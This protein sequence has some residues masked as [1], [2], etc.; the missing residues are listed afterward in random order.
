VLAALGRTQ[1]SSWDCPDIVFPTDQT[2]ERGSNK[3]DNIDTDLEKNLRENIRLGEKITDDGTALCD[4]MQI[5]E[6]LRNSHESETV[7]AS[8]SASVGKAQ[9]DRQM[10]RKLTD[11][12]DDRDSITTNDGSAGHSSPKVMVSTKD[13]LKVMSGGSRAGSVP[14]GRESSVK[15]ED[16]LEGDQLKGKTRRSSKASASSRRTA[17][18][19]SSV[20]GVWVTFEFLHG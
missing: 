19:W 13:R 6:A 4:K 18:R 14:A 5:L 15:A 7:T 12:I 20:Y 8:R 17:L 10:K 2:V 16:A 1:I 9:R 3:S 11:T